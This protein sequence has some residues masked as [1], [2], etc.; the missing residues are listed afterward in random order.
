MDYGY[1]IKILTCK[2][3]PLEESEFLKVLELYFPSTYDIK[4]LMRSCKKLKGGLQD[5]ADDM[6]VNRIGPQH[7]AGSDS[8]L[9]CVTFFKM[10]RMFFEDRIDDEKYKNRVFGLGSPHTTGPNS[11]FNFFDSQS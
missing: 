6:E 2:K 9:T 3:L 7:Q 11:H 10:R 5:V 1:L 4:Y 8:L